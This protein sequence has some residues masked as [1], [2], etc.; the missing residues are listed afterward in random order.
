MGEK[1]EKSFEER[2]HSLKIGCIIFGVLEAI[3]FVSNITKFT[4]GGISLFTVIISALIL[5]DI[6]FMYKYTAEK[7]P[8]G[9]LCEK[10]FGILLLIEGIMYCLTIVGIL[11]GIILIALALGILGEAKYFKEYIEQNGTEDLN[12]NNI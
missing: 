1:Q 5:V 9:P 8:K 11:I 4:A 3:A 12:D 10:I 7:N 6:Y 2:L